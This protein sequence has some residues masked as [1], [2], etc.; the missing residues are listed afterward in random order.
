MSRS[1][2]ASETTHLTLLRQ[3][4]ID[5]IRCIEVLGA[6]AK[7]EGQHEGWEKR[8]LDIG[9]AALR[10]TNKAADEEALRNAG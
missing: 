5:M 8:G 7:A 2:D 4:V 10:A 1:S 6:V 3:A 9:F